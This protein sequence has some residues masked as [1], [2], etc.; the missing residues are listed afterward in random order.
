MELSWIA[1]ALGRCS[2]CCTLELLLPPHGMRVKGLVQCLTLSN[3]S[4]KGGPSY[5]LFHLLCVCPVSSTRT[6]ALQEQVLHVPSRHGPECQ[7]MWGISWMFLL[8]VIPLGECFSPTFTDILYT[9]KFRSSACLSI[10]WHWNRLLSF[11][12][13][14]E[15]RERKHFLCGMLKCPIPAATYKGRP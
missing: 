15:M 11:L 6:S 5:I 3:R 2:S 14:I 12:P 7:Y 8:I 1:L 10:N 9:Q 4:V 13:A